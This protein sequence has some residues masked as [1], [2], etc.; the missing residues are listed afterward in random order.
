MNKINS[1]IPISIPYLYCPPFNNKKKNEKP[2]LKITV[3]LKKKGQKFKKIK[4]I[5][6]INL[7]FLLK[8]KVKQKKF[9]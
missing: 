7:K 4:Y 6:F 5:Y 3:N 1:K 9:Q 2:N 8:F